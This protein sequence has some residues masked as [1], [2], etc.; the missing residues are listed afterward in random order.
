MFVSTDGADVTSSVPIWTEHPSVSPRI[1]LKLS[2]R[3][4]LDVSKTGNSSP[5]GIVSTGGVNLTSSRCISFYVRVCR[6]A[7]DRMCSQTR[8]PIV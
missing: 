1:W 5:L 2:S 3:E 4:R 7:L 6:N 8:M